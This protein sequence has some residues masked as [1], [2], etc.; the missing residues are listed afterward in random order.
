[1]IGILSSSDPGLIKN[2]SKFFSSPKIPQTWKFLRAVANDVFLGIRAK[3]AFERRKEVVDS[4]YPNNQ[5]MGHNCTLRQTSMTI[6][7]KFT[8]IFFT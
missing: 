7:N 1:M 2:R 8:M 5:E 6:L 4:K 3:W